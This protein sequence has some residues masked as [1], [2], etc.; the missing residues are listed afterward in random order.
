VTI[1][2]PSQPLTD[3]RSAL[4]TAIAEVWE[5]ASYN[6]ARNWQAEP[7]ASDVFGCQRQVGLR[8]AGVEHTDHPAPADSRWQRQAMLGTWLHDK[9]LPLMAQA[10]GAGVI[11]AEVYTSLTDDTDPDDGA[12]VKGHLDLADDGRSGVVDLKSKSTAGMSRVRQE[13][14]S[15]RQRGQV[16]LY[17]KGRRQTG[18]RVEWVAL[19]FIDRE[20]GDDYTWVEPYSEDLAQEALLWFHEA[21]SSNLPWHLPRGGRGPGQDLMCD[22]CPFRTGCFPN[23]QTTLLDE[24]PDR[25]LAVVGA[26]DMYRAAADQESQAKKDKAFA[27]SLLAGEPA[28]PYG[29]WVLKWQST[30]RRMNQ[31]AVKELLQE[32]GEPVPMN[33]A[34][35]YPK[36][37]ANPDADEAAGD[38]A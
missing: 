23:G 7:G 31:A 36:I 19:V 2:H 32:L 33:D 26:L 5:L 11:E 24:A 37:S 4:R 34:S 16:M 27:A 1:T 38:A 13:G 6:H 21:R 29:P 10:L 8:F 14:P 15:R 12:G 22:E 28:G 35:Y 20:N 17:A 30:G 18:H 25:D 3:V 9:W